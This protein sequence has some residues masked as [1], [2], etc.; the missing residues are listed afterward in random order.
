MVLHSTVGKKRKTDL[1]NNSSNHRMNLGRAALL[2]VSLAATLGNSPS[3]QA[4][5][6]ATDSQ[7]GASGIGRAFEGDG[8][9][10]LALARDRAERNGGSS[11]YIRSYQF[12]VPR[13]YYVG[14]YIGRVSGKGWAGNWS[15][16]ADPLT[17]LNRACDG[18]IRQ[19]ATDIRYVHC[20]Q[21]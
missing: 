17:A 19:G 2:A 16:A 13:G 21:E 11:P 10:Q 15:Y 9:R 12:T 5:A 14:Y 3:V 18:L 4:G 20:W 1:M 7:N 8:N 6:V